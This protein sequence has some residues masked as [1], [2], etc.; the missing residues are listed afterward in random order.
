MKRT[1][2]SVIVLVACSTV[3][4][5]QQAETR[6]GTVASS[7][8]SAAANKNV[9]I[10]SGTHIRGELQKTIDVRNAKVGDR[11]VLKTTETI[12]SEGRKLV[13]KGALL[14]GQ[15]TEVTRKTKAKGESRIAILFD[16][17]K[18]G[19]LTLPITATIDSINHSKSNARLDDD[20]RFRS[21]SN[22][23]STSGSSM[24]TAPVSG[25]GGGGLVGSVSNTVGGAAN[26]STMAVGDVLGATTAASNGAISTTGR[27]AS[28]TDL[29]RSLSRIQISES[30]TTSADGSTVLSLANDNLR[31]E[32]GTTFNLTVSQS[33][34]LEVPK[35]P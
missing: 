17:I 35:Q 18:D 13:N 4:L 10:Q 23:Q 8:S 15:V 24:R 28:T 16:K 33:A 31:L 9:T 29:G 19:S 27:V 30:S 25:G 20:V 3:I 6:T 32:K 26:S 5:A 34:N 7:E 12:K 14:F 21:E 11:V 1:L 2:K 22:A